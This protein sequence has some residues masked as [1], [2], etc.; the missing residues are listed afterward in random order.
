[1]LIEDRYPRPIISSLHGLYSAGGLAGASFAGAAASADM[2]SAAQALGLTGILTPLVF[3][4]TRLLLRDETGPANAGGAV[5]SWPSRALLGLGVLAFLALMAEG[6]VGDWAAV[7]LREFRGVGMDRAATGFAG[8]SLAMAAGRFSGDWARRQWGGS[9][10]LRAGGLLAGLGI[11]IA[12]IMP[13][14]AL[15]VFGF[16]LFGFGLANMVPLLFGAAGRAEVGGAG[17]DIAAVATTGYGGLLA[18]PPLIGLLAE[19]VGLRLAL[20]TIMVGV[21]AVAVFAGLVRNGR[22][23]RT[24]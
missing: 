17:P 7:F 6:A 22:K 2:P 19:L 9:I 1:V 21:L 16:V 23:Q 10:L 20:V 11:A 5:L 18:G 15:S 13:G 4:A 12:L 24:V 3:V 8:F 14:L